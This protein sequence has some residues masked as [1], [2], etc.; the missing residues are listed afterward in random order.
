[1][2]LRIKDDYIVDCKQTRKILNKKD[3]VFVP[4]NTTHNYAPYF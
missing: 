2:L 3:L 1:M 4:S